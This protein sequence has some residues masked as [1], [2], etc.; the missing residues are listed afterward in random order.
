MSPKESTW[1]FKS[2]IAAKIIG[3]R[4]NL[5]FNQA[6]FKVAVG[7]ELRRMVEEDGSNLSAA[8]FQRSTVI[9]N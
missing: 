7:V 8:V 5:E 2:K 6:L 1:E 4:N 9:L 3:V